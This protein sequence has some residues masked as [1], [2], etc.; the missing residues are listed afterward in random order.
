[1]ISQVVKQQCSCLCQQ[2]KSG[3]GSYAKL[4]SEDVEHFATFLSNTQIKQD[5][6]ELYNVDWMK[7]YEGFSKLV[8][9]PDSTDQ[10]SKIL[11]YC[12]RQ[13]L[14]VVPQGGNTVTQLFNRYRA[15]G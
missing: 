15:E 6:L 13:R 7:R 14:A 4:R 3:F 5:N 11:E 1:M 12:S 9:L 2:L 8:L 10:L